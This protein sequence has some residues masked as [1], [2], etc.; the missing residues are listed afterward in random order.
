MQWKGAT[1]PDNMPLTFPKALGPMA[2]TEL[3]SIF[4]LSFI[5]HL[6]ARFITYTVGSASALT[7][8]GCAGMVV[9]KGDP[10]NPTTLLTKQQRGAAFTSS[11]EKEKAAMCIVLEWL[12]PSH[13]AAATCTG[14]Q[15]L[16]KAIQN[17]SADTTDLRR[18]LNKRAG[19][20]TPI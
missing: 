12:L 3:L 15:S 14:S 17:G 11:Y 20:T 8:N 5:R 2:K 10:V 4:N 7:L 6:H 1:G 19:K 18:M 9:T 13:A 16:L